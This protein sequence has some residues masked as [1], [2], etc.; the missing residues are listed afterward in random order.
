MQSERPIYSRA[1]LQKKTCFALT[2]VFTQVCQEYLVK[3]GFNHC[4]YIRHYTDGN[5]VV[6]TTHPDNTIDF[7]L[8]NFAEQLDFMFEMRH[9]RELSFFIYNTARHTEQ[10]V[11]NHARNVHK[12]GD[13]ICIIA[14]FLTYQEQFNLA[15]SSDSEINANVLINKID[16]L[17]QHV[18]F[19]RD[20]AQKMMKD[21]EKDKI[22]LPGK[23]IEKLQDYQLPTIDELF[24]QNPYGIQRYIIHDD[25]W[26]SKREFFCSRLWLIGFS[27]TEI[28]A[29]LKLSPKT[30]QSYIEN[31]KAKLNSYSKH[32]F[33]L[34]FTQ[35]F[36]LR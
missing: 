27:T 16:E 21:S 28:A 34:S 2:S 4:S 15:F 30:I 12:I 33:F 36:S 10:T 24:Q 11:F 13:G 31:A 17:H 3:Y 19:I 6:L 29:K 35:H 9:H 20:K 25:L 18:L 7:I 8:N 5:E 32:E 22:L 14:N 26:L 23:K 1:Q